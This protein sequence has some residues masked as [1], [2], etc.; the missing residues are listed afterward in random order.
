MHMHLERLLVGLHHSDTSLHMLLMH[1]PNRY[2]VSSSH[3]MREPSTFR[4]FGESLFQA[5]HCSTVPSAMSLA[6]SPV[7]FIISVMNIAKSCYNSINCISL[8]WK[9]YRAFTWNFRLM[10][11]MPALIGMSRIITATPA[12][13]EGPMV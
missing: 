11:A 5:V 2:T 10:T 1:M 13:T 7:D 6:Q 8:H 9:F 3:G 12:N 4:V